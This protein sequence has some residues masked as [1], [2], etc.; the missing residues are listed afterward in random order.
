MNQSFET[1]CQDLGLKLTEQRKII[2]KV[3]F[4]SID[5]PTTEE[6]Y[7]RASKIDNN[8]SLATVYRT[9]GLFEGYGVIEKLDFSDGKARYEWKSDVREHH[10]HLIDLDTGEVI[11]FQDDELE[12]LKERIAVRLGYKLVNHRLE[13]YGKK[14]KKI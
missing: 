5:H 9:V 14:I 12:E 11:E 7:N 3:L 6:V 13:L 2:A 10:H 4:E 1:L 8:I